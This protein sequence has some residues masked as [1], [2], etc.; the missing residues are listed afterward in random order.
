M[1]LAMMRSG[2]API[3]RSWLATMYHDGI[4]RQ[5]GS[6]GDGSP[7][8]RAARPYD[9]TTWGTPPIGDATDRMAGARPV[10][11]VT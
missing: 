9:G 4:V 7:R 6:F 8:R 2:A 3:A 10:A 1:R 5:A 11:S